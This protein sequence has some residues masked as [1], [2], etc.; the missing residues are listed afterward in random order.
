MVADETKQDKGSQIMTT[1][2]KT[3]TS[4]LMA[5]F[6]ALAF[7]TALLIGAI[8]PAVNVTPTATTQDYVA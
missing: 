2:Q 8:G 7:S 6:F 4:S 1:T 3:L 5:G